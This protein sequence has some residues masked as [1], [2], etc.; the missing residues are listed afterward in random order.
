MKLKQVHI[1]AFGGLSDCKKEFE[2]GLNVIYGENGAGKSSFLAFL[3]T[4]LYGF[5]TKGREK[6]SPWNGTA[7]HGS[8]IFEQDGEWL[9]QVKFGKTK[10]GD[11]VTF[12]NN[13]NGEE[14]MVP[15]SLGR[16]LF[17]MG[18]E[19]F[20]KTA[21]VTQG[22]LMIVK[23]NK[24]EIAE[25][26]ANLEHTGETQVSYG[27]CVKTLNTMLSKLRNR[28]GDGGLLNQAEQKVLEYREQEKLME[29]KISQG[30]ENYRRIQ[31]I[32]QELKLL[33][34]ME[35]QW[36]GFEKSEQKRICV[37][38]QEELDRLYQLSEG[39]DEEYEIYEVIAREWKQEEE[40]LRLVKEQETE[41]VTS[42]S[43]LCSQE[44]FT[45][46]MKGKKRPLGL[47]ITCLV[48][49][50]V[51]ALCGIL[52][53]PWCFVPTA[54]SL[55]GMLILAVRKTEQPW[56][57]Y[58]CR[59]SN[60]FSQKY[61]ESLE[62]QSASDAAMTQQKKRQEQMKALEKKIMEYEE[63][64]KH[65]NCSSPEQLF[66][67]C[68]ERR[69]RQAERKSA[70][71]QIKTY[72]ELLQ[73]A[74]AGKRMDEVLEVE[75]ICMPAL[76]KEELHQKELELAR[77]SEQLEAKQQHLYDIA[78]EMLTATRIEWEQKREEY[79]KKEQVLNVTLEVLEQAYQQMEQ[80]FGTN[81]NQ[82]AGELLEQMTQG[83]YSQVR[84]S[85]EYAVKLTEESHTCSLEQFSGGVFD[86][87]YLAFRLAMLELMETGAPLLLDDVLM[88]YDDTR[89]E[90]T[91]AVLDDYARRTGTQI[92]LFTC[93]NR[94]FDLAKQRKN[95]NCIEIL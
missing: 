91:I 14:R 23:D 31:E 19:T 68:S 51:F 85:K 39:A 93:R 53:T 15:E 4:C 79:R 24:D 54:L 34:K 25:K 82:R 57:A 86:Q 66:S 83:K 38:Y 55:I 73:K 12:F 74:L 76:S 77:E 6:Y 32:E 36:D 56:E 16:E 7:P 35:K 47:L 52:I 1:G 61:T 37:E 20:L 87:T 78:P 65:L 17:S 13:Q 41:V 71:T 2:S 18:A 49:A 33:R 44:E 28:R 50:A 75:D 21:C 5:E 62:R 22:Q 43:V 90:Q 81:L 26:L 84:I 42:A 80:Q 3:K 63:K 60:E 9:Y 64:G 45:R 88:Q 10:K 92:L 69:T 8:M 11:K 72:E 40:T 48:S 29:E 27:A 46:V 70:L 89:A 30:A 59:T 94:D 58:G 95:I 67:L